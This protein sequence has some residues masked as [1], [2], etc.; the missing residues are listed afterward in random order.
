MIAYSLLEIVFCSPLTSS[1]SNQRYL[2]DIIGNYLSVVP[3]LI[4]FHKCPNVVKSLHDFS[5]P[6]LISL[7]IH[8]LCL[9]CLINMRFHQVESGYI[10]LNY[11]HY[12]SLYTIKL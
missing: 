7:H 11:S 3:A 5:I 12:L 2:F 9:Y 8:N 4:D 6:I 10:C 1:K